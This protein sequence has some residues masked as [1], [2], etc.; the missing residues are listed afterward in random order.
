L[1]WLNLGLTSGS[2]DDGKKLRDDKLPFL[3]QSS[4][5]ISAIN[6]TRKKL[7]L[8]N[9]QPI[10]SE[11]SSSAIQRLMRT[12]SREELIEL[13]LITYD[14][15]AAT[16]SQEIIENAA[17]ELK[18]AS[19]SEEAAI[20]EDII[21]DMSEGATGYLG[22]HDPSLRKMVFLRFMIENILKQFSLD[23]SWYLIVENVVI[24]K[25]YVDNAYSV[26]TDLDIVID[27]IDSN[28]DVILRIPKGSSR[29]KYADAWKHIA[30]LV[31]KPQR[32]PKVDTNRERDLGIV[33]D[34]DAG[35][36]TV[37]IARKYFPRQTANSDLYSHIHKIY[38]R[39]SVK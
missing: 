5:F 10:Y 15:K 16:E 38:K 14:E 22:Y 6:Q 32:K 37:Q 29:K 18:S 36:K 9:K 11:P 20:Y 30:P 17:K 2:I 31:G 7:G 35:M 4:D 39:K 24:N 21:K 33:R 3:L 12:P 26:Y 28:G 1:F 23:E 25:E 19:T 27:S 8:T 34:M 13:G